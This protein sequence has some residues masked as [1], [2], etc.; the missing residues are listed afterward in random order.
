MYIH[1]H[2]H[3]FTYLE[4]HILYRYCVF[5]KNYFRES[6]REGE[7]R[8][9]GLENLRQPPCLAW[10][11]IPRAWDHDLSRNQESINWA[12]QSPLYLLILYHEQFPMSV[13]LKTIFYCLDNKHLFAYILFVILSLLRLFPIYCLC[14]IFFRFYVFL[15]RFF[16]F[17]VRIDF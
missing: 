5:L 9:R 16:V 15:I 7:G 14:N 6:K 11:S 3:K 12:T 1:T 4:L 13:V 8:R 17:L 10:G 2:A